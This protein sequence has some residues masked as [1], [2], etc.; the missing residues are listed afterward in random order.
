MSC[1]PGKVA[2]SAAYASDATP[3]Q[4]PEANGF[5]S[6]GAQPAADGSGYTFI[7]TYGSTGPNQIS[8]NLMPGDSDDP[9]I[10]HVTCGNAS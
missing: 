2:I 7:Y 3:E 4:V 5:R 9:A 8:P 6:F 1:L 10:A